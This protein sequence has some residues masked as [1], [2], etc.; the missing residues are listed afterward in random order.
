MRDTTKISY[1]KFVY[2]TIFLPQ[3]ANK[4]S[5]LVLR[6]LL[7]LLTQYF[8]SWDSFLRNPQ[9][10][11]RLAALQILSAGFRPVRY[12]RTKEKSENIWGTVSERTAVR[13]LGVT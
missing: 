7:R 9:I 6:V 12:F 2:F 1:K 3:Y 13:T 10:R 11:R 5:H 8:T 4:P